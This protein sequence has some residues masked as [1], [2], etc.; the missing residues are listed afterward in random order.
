MP[1]PLLSR[2]QSTAPPISS[3]QC[4]ANIVADIKASNKRK[5]KRKRSP[6]AWTMPPYKKPRL[7][8]KPSHTSTSTSN[9]ST[10]AANAVKAPSSSTL[11]TSFTS[12]NPTKHN[13]KPTHLSISNAK[14]MKDATASTTHTSSSV[15]A[16]NLT[17]HTT[18]SIHPSVSSSAFGGMQTDTQYR[19]I[20]DEWAKSNLNRFRQQKQRRRR[21]QKQQQQQ[22]YNVQ[23]R[24]HIPSHSHYVASGPNPPSPRQTRPVVPV[25]ATQQQ[26]Q[27]PQHPKIQ[28]PKCIPSRAHRV[29]GYHHHAGRVQYQT[30]RPHITIQQQRA[31]IDQQRERALNTPLPDEMPSVPS[32]TT[33]RHT[34]NDQTHSTHINPPTI[35]TRGM[36]QPPQDIAS[37]SAKSYHNIS[38]NNASAAHNKVN[39]LSAGVSGTNAMHPIVSNNNKVNA[40]DN[41]TKTK[42]LGRSSQ[43]NNKERSPAP[44]P[45]QTQQPSQP[46]VTPTRASSNPIP[47][48]APD[49]ITFSLGATSIP[50]PSLEDENGATSTRAE[51]LAIGSSSYCAIDLD[52]FNAMAYQMMTAITQPDDKDEHGIKI[53]KN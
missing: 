12:L 47:P 1:T 25:I 46:T 33:L 44:A 43:R 28:P 51:A 41:N 15:S 34:S 14:Q 13:A 17:K 19:R 9:A 23:Q 26:Q 53:E 29:S 7:N 3:N 16:L 38:V 10:S 40:K 2:L 42:A 32:T 39:P 50:L 36:A 8:T 27:Q 24:R 30:R 35:S 45:P 6:L 11:H 21:I 52:N 18:Q 22:H 20:C 5:C 31:H 48:K 37:V 49:A 4:I